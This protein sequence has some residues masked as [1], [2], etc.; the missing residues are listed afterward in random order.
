LLRFALRSLPFRSVGIG[1][2]AP[3]RP[4]PQGSIE[5]RRIELVLHR[6]ALAGHGGQ[7]A[8]VSFDCEKQPTGAPAMTLI[9]AAEGAAVAE[10]TAVAAAATGNCVE[11]RTSG[12]I[13]V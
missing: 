1:L 7:S 4:S 13:A 5:A 3:A 11:W 12:T 6:E 2:S 8:A 10:V 9:A